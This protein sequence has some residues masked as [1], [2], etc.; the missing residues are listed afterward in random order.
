MIINH[1]SNHAEML[2][3]SRT[4]CSGISFVLKH[5]TC[6]QLPGISSCCWLC[7]GTLQLWSYDFPWYVIT[8]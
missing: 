7:S 2:S 4:R 6:I 5:F 1:F 3:N 8:I